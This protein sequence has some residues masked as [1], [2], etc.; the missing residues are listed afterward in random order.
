M[1]T[2]LNILIYNI[3]VGNPT[4]NSKAKCFDIFEF[5]YNTPEILK[6]LTS[7]LSRV[8]IQSQKTQCYSTGDQPDC[9]GTVFYCR[10]GMVIHTI[11]FNAFSLE[12]KPLGMHNQLR[13]Q[14]I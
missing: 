1:K 11:I 13:P 9:L 10:K 6:N 3:A 14:A 5:W 4:G 7:L 12:K 2:T 8:T